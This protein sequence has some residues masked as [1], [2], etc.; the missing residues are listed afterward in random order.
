MN[1]YQS[2]YDELLDKIDQPLMY[3]SRLRNIVLETFKSVRKIN[4]PFMQDLFEVK[5]NKYNLR[6][7][8]LLDQIKVCTER[9]RNHTIRYQVPVCGILYHPT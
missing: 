8:I 1:D 6:G 2:S 4:P 9:Y 5:E 3:I 7:G